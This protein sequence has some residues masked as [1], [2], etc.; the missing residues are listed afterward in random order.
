MSSSPRDKTRGKVRNAV[1]DVF[2]RH[3]QC[4]EMRVFLHAYEFVDRELD[5]GAFGA[6]GWVAQ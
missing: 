2:V 3:L 4:L 5:K 1:H 6:V